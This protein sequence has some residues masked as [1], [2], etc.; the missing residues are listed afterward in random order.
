MARS[1]EREGVGVEFIGPLETSLHTLR[2]VRSRVQ[3][4]FGA[5][6]LYDRDPR[7]LRHYARQVESR[8]RDLAVD[9]I[10]SPGTIPI[11]YLD[12]DIPL[13]T[14]TDATFAG[15]LDYYPAFSKLSRAT[16]RCGHAVERAA[17]GRASAA[18]YSST[19]AARSAVE[20]YEADPDKVQVLPFGANLDIEPSWDEVMASIEGR[21]R[22]ECRLLFV[23]VDW[24][25]KGGDRALALAERLTGSGV[26]TRLTVIGCRPPRSAASGLVDS[27]GFSSKSTPSGAATL[28]RA[29]RESHFLC[30]PSRADCTPVVLCEAAAYGVPC[31]SVRTGGIESVVTDGVN[32][33][34][35]PAE[36]FVD[37]ASECVARYLAD[38][39]GSYTSLARSS[40]EEYG[41]RLNWAV[42]VRVLAERISGLIAGR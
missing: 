11:A 33:Y 6:Y 7:V 30:L 38:Y 5:A 23:G 35:F 39:D 18:L 27:L 17:L 31:L 2:Q 41:S 1:L 42:S 29:L 8:A 16:I 36:R 21:A 37:E 25:R 9:A 4:S 3:R 26:R 22:G 15:M 13:V 20:D 10:F 14:W 12:T 19:W 32:G 34:L 28:T 40:R 24:Y